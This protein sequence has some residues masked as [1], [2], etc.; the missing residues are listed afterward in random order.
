MDAPSA[1]GD[2]DALFPPPPSTVAGEVEVE[3]EGA[4][5]MGGEVTEGRP[6]LVGLDGVGGEAASGGGEERLAARSFSDIASVEGGGEVGGVLRGGSGAGMEARGPLT[7]VKAVVSE[8]PGGGGEEAWVTGRGSLPPLAPLAVEDPALPPREPPADAP[9]GLVEPVGG[10]EEA[11][12]LGGIGAA[13]DGTG[14]R[15]LRGGGGGGPT[16]RSQVTSF[17]ALFQ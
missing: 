5:E 6:G 3:V 8:E 13:V 4:G 17:V 12:E 10:G 2:G 11:V 7:R 15:P 14:D 9:A 1:L 16:G